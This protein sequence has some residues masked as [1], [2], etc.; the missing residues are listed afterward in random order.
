MATRHRFD[1]PVLKS[2]WGDGFRT[3]SDQLRSPHDLLRKA[4]SVS[5]PG[6]KGRGVALTTHALLTSRLIT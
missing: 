3:H 6:G 2:L 1:S 4:Y 5:F